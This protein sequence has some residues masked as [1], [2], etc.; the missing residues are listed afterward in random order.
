MRNETFQR[1]SSDIAITA[2]LTALGV[3][4]KLSPPYPEATA[5]GFIVA[6]C[7][8]L[9]VRLFSPIAAVIAFSTLFSSASVYGFLAGNDRAVFVLPVVGLMLAVINH[10]T[11]RIEIPEPRPVSPEPVEAAASDFEFVA[12]ESRP[13]VMVRSFNRD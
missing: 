6:V 13:G 2:L 12:D 5:L 9:V 1:V 8:F 11:P 7:V 4:L 3:F 10:Y